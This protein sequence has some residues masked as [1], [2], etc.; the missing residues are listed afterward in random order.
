M[1]ELVLFGVGCGF[2][3]ASVPVGLAG[4]CGARDANAKNK[5]KPVPAGYKPR[6][7]KLGLASCGIRGRG[8]LGIPDTARDLSKEEFDAILASWK[9]DYK[10]MAANKLEEPL[11]GTFGRN[12]PKPVDG[13]DIQSSP[14]MLRFG[15]F[16]QVKISADGIQFSG[17]YYTIT[18]HHVDHS[19]HGDS[20][21]GDPVRTHSTY[22]QLNPPTDWD[23]TFRRGADGEIYLDNFGTRFVNK[24][25]QGLQIKLYQ[26]GTMDLV[27]IEDGAVWAPD[28]NDYQ[29]GHGQGLIDMV[30]A[31]MHQGLIS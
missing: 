31:M 13:T 11:D 12:G 22:T 25:P 9:G 15:D 10:I 28:P 4:L 30:R 18:V 21:S 5:G 14:M 7:W 6:Q 16:K 1:A 29:Q 3:V 19:N 17:G 2:V 8:Y 27:R 23:T 20:D 24:G 26:G